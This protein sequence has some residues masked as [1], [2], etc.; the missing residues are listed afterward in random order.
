MRAGAAPPGQAALRGELAELDRLLAVDNDETERQ[1][2]EL[3]LALRERG[4]LRGFGAGRSV[5][6]RAYTLEDLRW[7]GPQA[8]PR[9]TPL[10]PRGA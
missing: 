3:V 6:R 1:A 2:V 9:S 7:V 8:P 5:P 4:M 10:R